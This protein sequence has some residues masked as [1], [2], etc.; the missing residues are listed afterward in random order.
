M[1]WVQ[2]MGNV[3]PA[4]ESRDNMGNPRSVLICTE[5]SLAR[6]S[7]S[8]VEG[9]GE[10]ERG[11]GRGKE[12][13]YNA[14]LVPCPHN[15]HTIASAACFALSTKPPN[16]PPLFRDLR[17]PSNILIFGRQYIYFKESG[18]IF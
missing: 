3:I 8:Q 6:E 15:Q 13:I 18:G 9:A 5:V 1:D 17:E 10:K 2:W 4:L 12:S 11:R 7:V 16:T 14:G